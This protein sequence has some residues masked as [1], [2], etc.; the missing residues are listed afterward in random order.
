MHSNLYMH[1]NI[2]RYFSPFFEAITLNLANPSFGG[3]HTTIS[4]RAPGARTK[5]YIK[6]LTLNGVPLKSPIIRHEQLLGKDRKVEVV[7]EMSDTI[8]SWGNDPDVLEALGI[9]VLR[10][11][12]R[13]DPGGHARDE[14]EL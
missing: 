11:G 10:R 13:R 6:S 14:A 4:I 2:L 7:Y 3:A 8:Q 12:A 1:T 9:D 5:P